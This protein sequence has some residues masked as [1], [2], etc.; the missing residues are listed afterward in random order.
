MTGVLL[1]PLLLLPWIFKCFKER[2]QSFAFCLMSVIAAVIVV[3]A[4]TE[5][6]GIL[7]RYYTDFSWMLY[8]AATIVLLAGY[9]YCDNCGDAFRMTLYRSFLVIAAVSSLAYQVCRIYVWYANDPYTSL[10]RANPVKFYE[11]AYRIA[12]WL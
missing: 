9:Q 2:K 4:D 3:V 1:L 6:A 11:M 7:F 8:L 5:M 12:F 10:S